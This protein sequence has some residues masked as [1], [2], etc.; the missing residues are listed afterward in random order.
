MNQGLPVQA[1]Q[2]NVKLAFNG[3]DERTL[4]LRPFLKWPG[5]KRWFVAQHSEVFPSDFNVYIE[6]FLGSGCV[7]FHLQPERALLGDTNAELIS[8]YRGVR[9]S[10]KRAAA[11]LGLHQEKHSSR[12]YYSVRDQSPKCIVERAAR[13]IYLNRACF[14]G[15]WRVNRNGKFNVPKGT[16]ESILFDS[17]DFASTARLLRNA[18]LRVADFEELVD[19]AKRDDL[20]FAD[21]PYTVR[22]NMNG[23]I[24]YNETL[25]S[26]DDQVRLA[27]ALARARRRGAHV[28]STNANHESL[29]NLYRSH[30]FWLKSVSRF[31]SVSGA[32]RSRRQFDELLILSG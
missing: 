30:G 14:N 31:S 3:R 5:G 4:P 15:I 32:A 25:F 20:V 29:R 9:K 12:Y 24:K 28:V 18:R 11:L 6:P 17:D 7:F 22:H 16:R 10:W 2:L 13:L 27:A 1:S 21:P 19:E 8:T 23:F 26:W